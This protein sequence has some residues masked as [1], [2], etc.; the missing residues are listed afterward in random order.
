[1][2][3]YTLAQYM[4]HEIKIKGFRIWHI[5]QVPGKAFYWQADSS[6]QAENLLNLLAEYD[7][8]QY[9]ECIKPDYT[10]A[11]GIECL[12]DGDWVDYEIEDSRYV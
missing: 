9:K 2:S 8:F 12:L 5:P 7:A 1:M 4:S 11:S 3:Q 10:S 6:A